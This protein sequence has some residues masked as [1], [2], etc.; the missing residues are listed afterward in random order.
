MGPQ[1]GSRLIETISAACSGNSVVT[2]SFLFTIFG[3]FHSGLAAL[4]PAAEE[5]IG[6]RAWRY[7]F[8][9]VSLPLAFSSVAY[10]LNHR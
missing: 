3:V 1:L 5:V 4:R 7:V 8:A 2:F 9:L 6:A 10:F